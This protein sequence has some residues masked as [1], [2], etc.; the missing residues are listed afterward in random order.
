MPER[1]PTI[2]LIATMLV[3]LLSGC[4][5]IGFLDE[6]ATAP[7][8]EA[9]YTWEHE[10]SGHVEVEAT[11]DGETVEEEDRDIDPLTVNRTVVNTT[12]E[13][14]E[15]PVYVLAKRLEQGGG[16]ATFLEAVRQRDLAPVPLWG[17]TVPAACTAEGCTRDGSYTLGDP[18][19]WTFLD[20][21]LVPG[22]TWTI[23]PDA[24]DDG[25]RF[26]VNAEVGSPTTADLPIGPTGI[27]PVTF[28]LEPL[29][30]DEELEEARRKMND[31]GAQ[32][33]RL[34]AEIDVEK[35]IGW[36]Q[37]HQT[38]A[39]VERR[40]HLEALIAGTDEDGESLDR[41]FRVTATSRDELASATLQAGPERAPEEVDVDGPGWMLSPPQASLSIDASET[42]GGDPGGSGGFWISADDYN[43]NAAEG[44]EVEFTVHGADDA[45]RVR[46][47]IRHADH[48]EIGQGE[49]ARLEHTVTD[50]GQHL[51][52]AELVDDDGEVVDRDELSILAWWSSETEM[53]CPLA[54]GD[55]VMA[56][57]P[58]TF[59]VASGVDGMGVY[60][61]PDGVTARQGEI[62]LL[63]ADD[64]VVATADGPSYAIEIDDFDDAAVDG[65]DWSLEYA[66]RATALDSP[67]VTVQARYTETMDDASGSGSSAGI[68]GTGPT[69]GWLDAVA[70]GRLDP[71]T[72]GWT[73]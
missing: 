66:P 16:A 50:P 14:D 36:S 12:L 42:D 68:L 34:E 10:R 28:T 61:Q 72:P 53:S 30:L 32:I 58:V 45:S 49:G 71:V 3:P 6:P 59:P 48:G 25:V 21:P 67:T 60:L 7:D 17:T 73:L 24:P 31:H 8:W 47:S 29:N 41:T 65:S 70:E 1:A 20:F 63:D 54:A 62:R 57:D 52:T 64:E 11:R 4:V 23:E 27:I 46:W 51:V 44:E 5:A 9:G 55:G 56:C 43:P 19:E 26:Q 37:T 15:E 33:D 18:P 22:K 38:A 2:L 13:A 35:E 69:P 39:L 40:G